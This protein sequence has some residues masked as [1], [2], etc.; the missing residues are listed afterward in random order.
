MTRAIDEI[1]P[2]D[3]CKAAWSFVRKANAYVEEVKP[4]ALAKDPEQRRRLEVVL[5][6]LADALRIMAVM[7]APIMPRAAQELWA[8]LDQ[9]GPV[10]DATFDEQVAW[11]LLRQGAAVGAG[12]A[13]FPRLET[14]PAG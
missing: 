7:L 12:E 13:L 11:G 1:A 8:R 3:A 6:Q 9:S 10:S 4:W 14:S 5:Y 2:H